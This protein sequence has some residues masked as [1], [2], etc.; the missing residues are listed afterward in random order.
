MKYR[1]KEYTSGAGNIYY[2]VEWRAWWYPF[3]NEW[4]YTIYKTEAH[5]KEAIKFA[6]ACEKIVKERIIEVVL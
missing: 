2:T 4:S 6:V 1:I 5:A 3:W